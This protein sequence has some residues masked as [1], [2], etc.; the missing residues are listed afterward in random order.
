MPRCSLPSLRNQ[1]PTPR[2]GIPCGDMALARLR[3][4]RQ[5]IL[6]VK[7]PSIARGGRKATRVVRQFQG[8]R[9]DR[10]GGVDGGMAFLSILRSVLICGMLPF[11]TARGLITAFIIV[12]DSAVSGLFY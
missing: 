6:L 3:T 7:H 4:A 9:K 8:K 12:I 1:T 11:F 10:G 2:D 5:L